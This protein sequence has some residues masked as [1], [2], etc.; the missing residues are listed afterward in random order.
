MKKLIPVI[1]V[2][3]L[4]MVACGSSVSVEGRWYHEDEDGTYLEFTD[5]GTVMV[6]F[7]DI[8]EGFVTLEAGT[9]QV[10]G[11]KVEMVIT[12]DRETK[13]TGIVDGDKMTV[14]E[15]DEESLGVFHRR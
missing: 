10:R 11:N 2:A 3:M 12:I 15:E 1:M 7:P 13:L 8:D 9:Y 6:G 4:L 14:T 5:K